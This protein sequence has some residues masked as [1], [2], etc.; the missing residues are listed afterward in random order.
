MS[1][2]YASSN[3]EGEMIQKQCFIVEFVRHV[4]PVLL[5]STVLISSGPVEHGDVDGPP[6]IADEGN[7]PLST[8]LK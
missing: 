7:E 4:I 8:A 3:S 6:S 5:C 2:E 1:E